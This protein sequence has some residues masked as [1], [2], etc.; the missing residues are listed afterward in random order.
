MKHE[1]PY[2]G[3]KVEG[4]KVCEM[5]GL[6]FKKHYVEMMQKKGF[7]FS[8]EVSSPGPG[9]SRPFRRKRMEKDYSWVVMVVII[10][11]IWVVIILAIAH[12]LEVSL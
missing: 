8:K 2:C 7:H 4:V 1:C 10:L 6:D 3:C 5:C 12:G 9:G 11:L